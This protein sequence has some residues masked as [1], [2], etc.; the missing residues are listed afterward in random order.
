M[1]LVLHQQYIPYTESNCIQLKY[2]TKLMMCIER[3]QISNKGSRTAIPQ[4]EKALFDG[5]NR[6]ELPLLLHPRVLAANN[7]F[8]FVYYIIAPSYSG[9]TSAQS[10]SQTKKVF[11]NY[12]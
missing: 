1:Q 6:R 4:Q 12:K 9:T 8:C 3:S 5:G 2:Q 11:Q 7:I 10:M